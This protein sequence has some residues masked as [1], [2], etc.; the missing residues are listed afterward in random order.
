LKYQALKINEKSETAEKT[1]LHSI[2]V[3]L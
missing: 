2:L 1:K 3:K